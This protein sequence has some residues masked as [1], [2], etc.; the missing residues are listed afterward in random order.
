M[1]DRIASLLA[2][3]TEILY[4]LGLGDR[5]VAISHECDHPPE[6]G[7]KPRVTFA[8][9]SAEAGSGEIDR[10]VQ[11]M[12]AAREPLYRI[13]VE[14]LA[15]LRPDL[16]VT[17][18]QC[19]VCAVSLDDVRRAV[20]CVSGLQSAQVVALNPMTLDGVYADILRVGEAAGVADRAAD[21]VAALRARVERVRIMSGEIPLGRR[22]RT[23]CVEWI[24]PLMIAANWMPELIKIAGG[25]PGLTRA[26][27]RTAYADWNELI[28]CDPE[29]IVIAP[30]GFDLRR[31]IGEAAALSRSPG[32][33]G[34]AAVREGRV[35]AADGNAYF[36]RSGPRLVDTLE[37]L[38]GLLHP[39]RFAVER[40]RF[41]ESFD[42]L[43]G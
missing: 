43:G 31:T 7:A 15:E 16:I 10:Q 42:Q 3:G 20:E 28:A 4:G 17:Q 25:R 18:S 12:V 14:R 35:F 13:D 33:G 19:E 8:N 30:C 41:A 32:W 11:A 5:V 34:L 38:A 1:A 24:E 21:Y 27:D 22:P 6:I 36:N 26:G 37:L 9:I 2:S 29:V 40:T 23:V 39:D